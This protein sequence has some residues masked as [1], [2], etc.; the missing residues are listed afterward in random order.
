MIKLTN[1]G[2]DS[3]KVGKLDSAI[4]FETTTLADQYTWT[5]TTPDGR[6]IDVDLIDVKHQLASM[7]VNLPLIGINDGKFI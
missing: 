7:V 4:A 5:L 6:L 3:G 1:N 2:L